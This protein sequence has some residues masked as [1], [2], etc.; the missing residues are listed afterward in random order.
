MKI[1]RSLRIYAYWIA[2][3]TI[4]FAGACLIIFGLIFEHPLPSEINAKALKFYA[5][6][7]CLFGPIFGSFIAA[8]E[9]RFRR[10][11]TR[12]ESCI[13]ENP[14]AEMLAAAKAQTT[15]V[16]GFGWVAFKVNDEDGT[17]RGVIGITKTE[18]ELRA[19][20]RHYDGSLCQFVIFERSRAPIVD[21]TSTHVTVGTANRDGSLSASEL[22][23]AVST[24]IRYENAEWFGS[25]GIAEAR[26][27]L[28]FYV[29]LNTSH[30]TTTVSACEAH[31]Q[32]D[33]LREWC[34]SNDAKVI[35]S[36]TQAGPEP[37]IA[38]PACAVVEDAELESPVLANMSN[39]AGSDHTRNS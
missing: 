25:I 26:D 13:I 23:L 34:R 32:F 20:L 17:P 10:I 39:N 4:V 27:K 31:P 1:T 2:G 15:D 6:M 18:V 3:S 33:R 11:N 22:A 35:F 28:A 38:E 8:G 7:T 12:F 30:V 16:A 9:L 19:Y 21:Y 5:I 37:L 14:D 36:W 24:A 29:Y